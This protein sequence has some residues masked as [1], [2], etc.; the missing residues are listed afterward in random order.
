MPQYGGAPNLDSMIAIDTNVLVRV[1]VDDPSE[2]T[3]CELARSLL[4]TADKAWISQVVLV[5]TV[6]VL[7]SA[8]GFD[9]AAILKVL[10]ELAIH[11]RLQIEGAEALDGALTLF[12][13]N[14]TDFAD[15][16]IL[17]STLRQQ[18]TLFTFDAKLSRLDGAKRLEPS[19]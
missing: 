4:R 9:K 17:A 13:G 7:E 5:E 16:L 11:E 3:Q 6:W 1:L 15:C 2:P 19:K 8:F 14:H 12:S 10:Q 18:L